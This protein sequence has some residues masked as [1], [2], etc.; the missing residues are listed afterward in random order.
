MFD[1]GAL[2]LLGDFCEFVFNGNS[3]CSY[4][5]DLMTLAFI[6]KTPGFSSSLCEVFQRVQGPTMQAINV[7]V[8]SGAQPRKTDGLLIPLAGCRRFFL[9]VHSRTL[10][11][12]FVDYQVVNAFHLSRFHE[13]PPGL[14]TSDRRGTKRNKTC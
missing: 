13:T 8:H 5:I 2:K 9:E 10:V 6:V 7:L 12:P 11:T 1:A 4:A 14:K 3:Q